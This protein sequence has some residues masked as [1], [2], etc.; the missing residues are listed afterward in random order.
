MKTLNL[1]NSGLF[2]KES[3][4][5]YASIILGTFILAVGI[6]VFVTPLKV[7]PGGVYGIAIILHHLFE[8]PL[9][10]SGISMEMPLL[11]AGVLF[12]GPRFGLKTVVGIVSLAGF[13][14]LLENTYGYQPLIS[15]PSDPSTAD[16]ASYMILSLF[17]AVL[18]GIGMGLVFKARATSGG[19]DIIAM[20]IAKYVKHIPLGTLIILVDSM[21]VLAGL[22]IFD[23]WMVPLYSFLIIYVAGFTIDL[24]LAG[25]SKRK[26]LII[27]SKEH[28]TIRKVILEEMERGGTILHGAG[29]YQKNATEVLYT[30]ISSKELP[31]LLYRIHEIDEK[32]FISILEAKDVIGEGFASLKDKTTT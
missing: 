18:L 29:M 23:N 28:E 27:I 11:L 14:S 10:L 32:A 5:E 9:G 8:Y 7:V 17:G 26:A 6:V 31:G 25:F 13:I 3:L 30:T 24:I 2:K 22:I 1:K 15:L 4:K 12:L 20:I 21:V 19:T 16:P